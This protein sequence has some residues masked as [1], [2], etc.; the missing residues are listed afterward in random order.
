MRKHFADVFVA[1]LA[2]KCKSYNE[3]QL[4]DGVGGMSVQMLLTK[5]RQKV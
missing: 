2:V 1:N 5:C 3:M 4:T